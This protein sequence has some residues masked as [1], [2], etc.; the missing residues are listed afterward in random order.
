MDYTKKDTP[1]IGMMIFGPI[2]I[3]L[4]LVALAFGYMA[5]IGIL[6]SLGLGGT[7]PL[8]CD[9]DFTCEAYDDNSWKY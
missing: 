8:K 4:G 9:Q 5:I 2:G 7:E 6:T 3:T 1:S